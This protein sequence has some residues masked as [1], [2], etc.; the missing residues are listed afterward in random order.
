MEKPLT[1]LGFA[2]GMEN[3]GL[4]FFKRA[5]KTVRDPNAKMIF[6][7][8]MKMEEGHIA[9]IKANIE[10]IKEKGRWQLKPIEG[11]DEGKTAETVFKAREEGKAGE[12]EFEIGEMTSDLSA[13]RIALAIENDL[14]EFYS[15]ASAHAKG[16]DA[17]AVFK[18]L[19]EWEK[20]HREMLE[21]QYEEMREGFWSKMGFS[22]FD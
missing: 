9:Y 21:A 3:N 14:Y 10:S 2:L 5:A 17:K 15:R 6:L 16:Q 1:V 12:T 7:D 18:K 20:E 19:S 4:E 8:L 22:P 13:I 11:Y